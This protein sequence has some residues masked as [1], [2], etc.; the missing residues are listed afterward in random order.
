MTVVSSLLTGELLF[1]EICLTRSLKIDRGLK[2]L[3]NLCLPSNT[4][5]SSNLPATK[6][7]SIS[8]LHLGELNLQSLSIGLGLTF[9]L[10]LALLVKSN[11]LDSLL[12]GDSR[13]A[14]ELLL[15]SGFM[16]TSSGV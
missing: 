11:L 15:P 14:S 1:G 2:L 9:G 7:G 8:S 16:F 13:L 5:F 10:C 12:A 6:A 4:C 3:V